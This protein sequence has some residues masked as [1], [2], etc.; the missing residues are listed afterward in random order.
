MSRGVSEENL[1]N[2]RGSPP[3]EMQLE[4]GI[5]SFPHCLLCRQCVRCPSMVSMKG[6]SL[7]IDI[8]R[9]S[10]GWLAGAR[11]ATFVYSTAGADCRLPCSLI[12]Q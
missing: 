2:R 5:Y 4:I 3:Q 6:K 10:K 7:V 1:L 8:G 9:G 12:S 11:A